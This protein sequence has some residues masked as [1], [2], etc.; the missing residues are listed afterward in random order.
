MSQN[1]FNLNFLNDKTKKIIDTMSLIIQDAV[2]Y[3]NYLGVYKNT[4]EKDQIFE[5]I[6]NTCFSEKKLTSSNKNSFL[7]VEYPLFYQRK[8]SSGKLAK[9]SIIYFEKDN[10]YLRA[11]FPI[12]LLNKFTISFSFQD[13]YIVSSDSSK[14]CLEEINKSILKLTKLSLKR[15]KVNLSN[16]SIEHLIDQVKLL[17]LIEY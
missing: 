4:L 11:Q 15:N 7:K 16:N 6:I 12:D 8:S 13:G 17:N 10:N 3:G 5:N 2:A 14:N 1:N 9:T